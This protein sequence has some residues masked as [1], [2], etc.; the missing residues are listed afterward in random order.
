MSVKDANSLF[1]SSPINLQKCVQKI[2]MSAFGMRTH[3]SSHALA[4]QLMR[5]NVRSSLFG[6]V[7]DVFLHNRKATKMLQRCHND[8]SSIRKRKL[9]GKR[10]LIKLFLSDVRRIILANMNVKLYGCTLTFRVTRRQISA[11]VVMLLISKLPMQFIS[12][13]N[14]EKRYEDWSMFRRC[15]KTKWPAFFL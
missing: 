13:F 3:A 14:S 10:K 6:V 2:E 15:G 1:V 9:L 8:V 5:Q 7:P 11:E 4:G 12:E